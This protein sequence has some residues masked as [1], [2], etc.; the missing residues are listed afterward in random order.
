MHISCNAISALTPLLKFIDV[1]LPCRVE[2][3]SAKFSVMHTKC[4][5]CWSATFWFPVWTGYYLSHT[6]VSL[7][8]IQYPFWKTVGDVMYCIHH[9]MLCTVYFMACYVLYT[10]WHVMYCILHGMLWTAHELPY[11]PTLHWN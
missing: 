10:S 7:F 11:C 4:C 6:T 8:C 2:R 9:G 3:F 1:M 5:C